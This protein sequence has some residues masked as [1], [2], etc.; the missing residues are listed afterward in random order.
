MSMS[1]SITK[2]AAIAAASLVAGATPGAVLA[3]PAAA[4]PQRR[5][6]ATSTQRHQRATRHNRKLRTH[7]VSKTAHGGPQL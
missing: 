4:H 5:L 3:G 7:H 2:T 1:R 6:A